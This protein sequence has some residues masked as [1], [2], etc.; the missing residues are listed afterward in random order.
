[1]T[2]RAPQSRIRR[3]ARAGIS[4]II[5]AV[6]G[7]FDLPFPFPPQRAFGPHPVVPP[8]HR[9]FISAN[10]S[11][12][13]LCPPAT[14]HPRPSR[15][16][17]E[18]RLPGFGLLLSPTRHRKRCSSFLFNFPDLTLSHRSFPCPPCG[19]LVALYVCF[20]TLFRA[21]HLRCAF[22][23]DLRFSLGSVLI[24]QCR[25]KL[26]ALSLFSGLLFRP[27]LPHLRRSGA[28]RGPGTPSLDYRVAVRVYSNM[29]SPPLLL[30]LPPF[31]SSL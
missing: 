13:L 20:A 2:I 27:F 15:P 6:L 18:R 9:T 11:I 10:N 5:D 19:S 16:Q 21:S 29:T 26:S 8:F 28:L 12:S 7:P 22:S 17:L 24:S 31:S 23:T 25:G 30:L 3:P 14:N 1:L 4:K